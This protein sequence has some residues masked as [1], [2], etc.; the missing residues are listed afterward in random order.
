VPTN[1]TIENILNE[2]FEWLKIAAQ[3]SRRSLNSE[4]IVCLEKALRKPKMPSSERIARA[5][6]LR[7]ELDPKKFNADDIDQF[8]HEGRR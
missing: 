4:A 1:L 5:V 2:L 8:K 3:I 6:A 7:V